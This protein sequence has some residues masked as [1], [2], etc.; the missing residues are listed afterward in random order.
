MKSNDPIQ[1]P[2]EPCTPRPSQIISA[3]AGLVVAG[4][5]GRLIPDL[6]KAAQGRNPVETLVAS[7]VTFYQSRFRP[8][9][10]PLAA[11]L[12][13]LA[14]TGRV[15][16]TAFVRTPP[17]EA[18]LVP[19]VQSRLAQ[20][21]PKSSIPIADVTAAANAALDR[22]YHVALALRGPYP[23]RIEARKQ[24]QWIAVSGEDDSPHRPV[25]VASAPYP[26]HEIPVT[27]G[28]AAVR[29]GGAP[30]PPP[31]GTVT[32]Q[33]RFFIASLTPPP[34]GPTPPARSVPVDAPPVVPD[35]DRVIL[36]VH[37]HSSNAEE[38]LEL[39]PPLLE[40]GKNCGTRFSVISL[41]LP[42]NGYSSMIDHTA[43][44]PSEATTFPAGIR[45]RGPIHTP[46]LDF[47]ENFVVAF[48]DALD[49]H[50]PIKNRF[51]GVIGGSLG[52]NL[53]LRLGRRDLHA[54]Q[55]LASGIVSWSPASVW[56][57]MVQDELKRHGPE[58]CRTNWNATETERSR[59]DY[60]H[61]VYDH[62]IF[63]LVV[64]AQPKQ[65]YRDDWEPCKT[66]H[67]QES[68]SGRQEIYN[69][70]FRRWHYRLAGEQLIF[71]HVDHVDHE[72]HHTPYR[73]ELN[74]V[75][76]L[77][78]AG[79]KDNYNYSDIYDATRQ[80]A[81]KMVHTPGFSLFLHDTGHSIHAERPRFLATEIAGFFAVEVP[82]RQFAQPVHFTPDP[83]PVDK[84]ITVTVDARDA[85]TAKP[86]PVW[87]QIDGRAVPT[88]NNSF[89]YT[90][91]APKVHM[92][93]KPGIGQPV[94]DYP[95]G[96]IGASGYE[97]APLQLRFQH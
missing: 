56:A 13:D 86:V 32:I 84:P 52:G 31:P 80:L 64:P 46:I 81:Q 30:P 79:E 82:R 5:E 39:I 8:D 34:A 54:C 36:F 37:G 51:A 42:C 38:A 89:T 57:P 91:P 33:T 75:R 3:P 27:I 1:P 71:S 6:R 68:R 78:A 20:L 94:V 41:D 88:R 44:A 9:L 49:R 29:H 66:I 72:N 22:A 73:Y 35:G 70:W 26:Q 74:T 61:D 11:A 85:E 4:Q 43:V 50:T 19:A 12:A 92:P 83:L 24:L 53:G 10:Q 15:S 16:Y 76:Q 45:D 40:A 47:V 48:L 58:T 77:L 7:A 97:P 28:P 60:F 96:L 18:M 87:V 59:T 23:K 63:P 95:S 25:N 90:F 93:P 69:Q 65:W 67:I 55:W 2:D 21:N 14:V 17:T 62:D